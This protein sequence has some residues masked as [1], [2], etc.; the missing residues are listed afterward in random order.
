MAYRYV[1]CFVPYS[2]VVRKKCLAQLCPRKQLKKKKER[3]KK[4]LF[5]CSFIYHTLLIPLNK[6]NKCVIQH[7]M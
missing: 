3:K 2:G 5:C 6:I 4:C 7:G 1:H